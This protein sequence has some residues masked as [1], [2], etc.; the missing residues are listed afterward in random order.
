M[1]KIT[2]SILFLIFSIS[3]FSQTEISG[4][5]LDANTRKPVD[6]A[7]I[8]VHPKGSASIL[9]YTMTNKNGEFTLKRATLP[10][11]VTITVSAMTIKRLS[12]TVRSDISNIDFMVEEQTLELN[13]VIVK[14]PK[15]RQLGDTIHYDV[16]SFLDETDRS[17]GDVLKKLPGVQVLSSGQI[18]Y[19]NKEISKFYIEGLDLLQGKYGLATQN[20]DADKVASVQ[21][22]ENHQPVKALKDMEVPDNAAINLKL[23]QSAVGAF[24]ATAQIGAG[25][26]T[27]LLSNEGVGMRFT[28]S[29][30]NMIVYKGDNSGRDISKELTSY[31]GFRANDSDNM[32]SVVAPMPPA[33]KEQHHLFNDAHLVSLNDLRTL[34]KDLTLTTN[35]NFLHDNQKRNS[36]SKSDIYL[37]PTDT[38]Q[39]AEDMD[40]RFLKREL[41]GSLV[42]EGNAQ[43]YFIN[44]K[45]NIRSLWNSQNSDV[46]GSEPVMQSLSM[47]SFSIEN[48]FD[49]LRRNDS[50]R[51]R[52]DAKVAYSTR[53]H[54]LNTSPVLFEDLQNPDSVVSQMI[55]LNKF[56]ASAQVSGTKDF[57]RYSFGFKTGVSFLQYN[58]ESNMFSGYASVPVMADSLKNDIG[59]TELKANFA[60]SLSY[61]AKSG[62]RI[63][64]DAPLSVMLLD[65]SDKIKNSSSNRGYLLM[66]PSTYMQYRVSSRI[67]G[68]TSLSYANNVGGISG[69]YTG[70]I[71]NTYRNMN[72][73]DGMLSKVKNT[74][75]YSSLEYKNPFTTL[76]MSLR[77]HYN[78]TWRNMLYDVVYND[79]MSSSIGI[80]HP[81]TSHSWGAGYSMSQSVDA[82]NSELRLNLNYNHYQS[83]SLNQDIISKY[84]S[85]NYSVSPN[86]TTS[87]GRFMIVKYSASYSHNRNKIR[88]NSMK[89]V[90]N[91]TQNLATSLI[92]KKGITLT[93]SFN[94]YYNN[95][96]ESSARSSWFGNFSARYRAKRV[97]WMLDWSNVFNTREF[98]NYSYSDISSH[99][100][101]YH[102]RPSEVMLRVRF[103][104]L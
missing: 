40:A 52:V 37:S 7:T 98:I 32:L 99:Y 10:D 101:V 22:L 67:N 41:E 31:Y 46:A 33:I 74:S 70:Y 80:K 16:A 87:L 14:A 50:W 34:K 24:F 54:T 97:D 11:S 63:F 29:Q 15:M 76:F 39:I 53:E 25:L 12:K 69:D 5:V 35:I 77:L 19:Q 56:N 95:M 86:I 92:P 61:R 42:L 28:R 43:D 85:D 48:N 27:L 45:L 89:P 65:R 57:K 79:I 66:H 30:Q 96:I 94:H 81:H 84:N 3:V 2:L 20:V 51:K 23:K 91:F 64:F 104:I 49:Y 9:A 59:R 6:A 4:R 17:I 44:N 103:K 90:N 73:S 60:P 58:M 8:T 83:L 13:E 100:S 55:H 78:N 36:F 88:G 93:F 82:I 62:F 75:A 18:L 26:P 71:M 68:S 47:P 1:Y 21:V 38:V 102:L 72:R